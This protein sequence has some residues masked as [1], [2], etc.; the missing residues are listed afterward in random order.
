MFIA[1]WKKPAYFPFLLFK[2]N[3]KNNNSFRVEPSF[4]LYLFPPPLLLRWYMDQFPLEILCNRLKHQDYKGAGK[5]LDTPCISIVL[6]EQWQ[7]VV[8]SSPYKL[9][10]LIGA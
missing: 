7:V 8:Y 4:T 2:P 6:S 3:T 9:D 5:Q 1:N 10:G